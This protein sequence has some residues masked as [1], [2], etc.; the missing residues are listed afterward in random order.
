VW[1]AGLTPHVA[2]TSRRTGTAG[3]GLAK[4]VQ[5]LVLPNRPHLPQ[6]ANTQLHALHAA[7]TR[8]TRKFQCNPSDHTVEAHDDST[9]GSVRDEMCLYQG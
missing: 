3:Q 4:I 7:C 6:G 5:P 1:Q 9:A 8:H 2:V